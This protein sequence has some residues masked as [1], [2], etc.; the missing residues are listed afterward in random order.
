MFKTLRNNLR[1]YI[2][3]GKYLFKEPSISL[4][5][6]YYII[7]ALSKKG[8]I[9]H[10]FVLLLTPLYYL[11]SII[12]GIEIPRT[13]VI[14]PGLRIYHHGG[15]VI[16][17]LSIIGADCKIRHCVTIGNKSDKVDCP[18]IGDNCD[19]GAGAKV[20]GR[21]KVGDNVIIGANAVLVKDLPDNC[22]AVGVPAEIKKYI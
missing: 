16:N 18:I 2:C 22:I 5:A 4:V 1:G 14:G 13:T 17:S 3:D 15:I 10:F 11:L 8:K 12:L 7:S 9:A 19:I 6:L 20:L 21:I